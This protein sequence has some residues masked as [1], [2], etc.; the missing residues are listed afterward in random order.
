MEYLTTDLC[1]AHPDKVII[2]DPVGLKNYGGKK[3]FNGKIHTLKCFEDHSQVEKI[4]S[5]DGTGKVLI[6]DGGGSRCCALTGDRLAGIGVK[7]HWNGI[8]IYGCIRDSVNI[9]LLD[10]GVKALDTYPIS[11]VTNIEWPENIAVRF[12]GVTFAPGQFV[13]SDED[14]IIISLA[15]L[16]I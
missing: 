12:A 8:I 1:D 13:Y 14:G 6:V 10:I 4:L 7:N 11:R 3:R 15:K 9:A 5:T 16:T 2:A